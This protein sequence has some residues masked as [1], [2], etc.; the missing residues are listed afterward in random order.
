MWAADRWLFPPLDSVTG[1]RMA[2]RSAAR[3][4]ASRRGLEWS[5]TLPEG[6]L[7]DIGSPA[8]VLAEAAVEALADV[9]AALA[10]TDV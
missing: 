7:D 1:W 2:H 6:W 5:P 4:E 3:T 10:D 8:H 9:A